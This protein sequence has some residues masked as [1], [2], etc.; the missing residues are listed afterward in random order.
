MA[1]GSYPGSDAVCKGEAIDSNEHFSAEPLRFSYHRNRFGRDRGRD[2]LKGKCMRE[3]TK[4]KA[5]EKLAEIL[6]PLNAP[7]ISSD[8]TLKSF[9]E[10]VYFPFYQRKWKESTL[11][12]N[13]DRIRRDIVE[14]F[15]HRQL[16]TSHAMNSKVFLI[17]DPRCRSARSNICAGIFDRFSIWRWRKE[18]SP[19]TRRRC[20]S[21]RGTVQ[22][23]NIG[24]WQLR[25]SNSR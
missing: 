16:R 9:I 7:A 10:D 5:Q 22:G 3:L 18:S 25:R 21:L 1:A 24:R 6:K 17:P 2:A 14:D 13:K 8:V 19:G 20:C 12:T 23:R 15:G 11:M 4:S